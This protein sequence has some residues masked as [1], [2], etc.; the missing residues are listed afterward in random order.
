MG[1]IKFFFFADRRS[2]EELMENVMPFLVGVSTDYL[3]DDGLLGILPL[4]GFIIFGRFQILKSKIFRQTYFVSLF[5]L[6]RAFEV[7]RSLKIG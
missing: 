1:S 7:V 6:L 4:V 5:T 3:F 2:S